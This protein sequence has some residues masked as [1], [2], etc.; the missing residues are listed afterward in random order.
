MD[1]S[2]FYIYTAK[3]NSI[4]FMNAFLLTNMSEIKLEIQESKYSYLR[5]SRRFQTNK[6]NIWEKHCYFTYYIIILYYITLFSIHVCELKWMRYDLSG[7]VYILFIVGMSANGGGGKP[8]CPVTN[9]QNQK[10]D[11]N[12]YVR[13]GAKK[14]QL[15]C[16]QLGVGG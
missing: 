13:E 10:C 7:M 3:K 5:I 4:Y 16:L 12:Y 15:T 9:V 1:K 6:S 2:F 8:F 14:L 11:I